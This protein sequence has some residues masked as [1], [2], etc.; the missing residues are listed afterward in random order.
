[1]QRYYGNHI[2]NSLIDE[3]GSDLIFKQ[4]LNLAEH[5]IYGSSRLGVKQ[6]TS[7][8]HFSRFTASSIDT[9]TGAIVKDSI[10]YQSTAQADSVK[11]QR[12]LGYKSYELS[13]HLGNVLAVVSDKRIY[14]SD[15]T[16]SGD[17]FA[18]WDAHIISAQDYYPF[19]MLMPNRHWV[20]GDSSGYKYGFNGMERD[21]E[22]NGVGAMY[23]YGF[24]IYDP[25]LSR[26]LSV[27]P[28]TKSFPWY[29][30]F[31]FAGNNPVFYID[32]DGLEEAPSDV[33]AQK[34]TKEQAALK[35]ETYKSLFYVVL[36]KQGIDKA[37]VPEIIVDFGIWANA[38]YKDGK[39]STGQGLFENNARNGMMTDNDRVSVLFHEF[40]HHLNEGLY[41]VL[42]TDNGTGG[43]IRI[44][45]GEVTNRHLTKEEIESDVQDYIEVWELTGTPLEY[46]EKWAYEK[47]EALK[48][49]IL[50]EEY[51]Y[52]PSNLFLDE[53]SA[54]KAQLEAHEN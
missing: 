37:D 50:E 9:N 54:Y 21:N 20:E 30:P 26:F 32:L 40:Q 18:L 4:Q 10:L 43:I 35:L 16:I 51:F 34:I 23:D 24:R 17:T 27:D 44:A 7:Q 15:T 8:M 48:E 31:Q 14:I 13:N 25:R 33:T 49:V 41:P 19:G 42:R 3:L 11:T 53:I 47:R 45:T 12:V 1:M 46:I 29:T 2:L 6:D 39:I 52:S 38:R 22:W 28:L 36:E 5:N